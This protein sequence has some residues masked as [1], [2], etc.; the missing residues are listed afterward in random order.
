MELFKREKERS[1]KGNPGNIGNIRPVCRTVPAD[2]NLRNSRN[3]RTAGR[4]HHPVDPAG[5]TDG[6][7]HAGNY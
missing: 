1:G 3:Q 4:I 5:F 2:S 6:I 7:E